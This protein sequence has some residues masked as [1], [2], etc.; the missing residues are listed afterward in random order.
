MAGQKLDW[1]LL[2]SLYEDAGLILFE[3]R[4]DRRRNPRN[5]KVFE[6][7]VL[8]SADWVYVV[9]LDEQRRSVQSGQSLHPQN[10]V[11]TVS[12]EANLSAQ[13]SG[14]SGRYCSGSCE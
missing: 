1:D 14:K 4:I 2:E 12:G 10:W 5:G 7:L 11:S 13:A 3:K 9:A 6:H 8:E